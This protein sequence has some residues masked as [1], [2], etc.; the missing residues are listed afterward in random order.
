MFAWWFVKDVG[1]LGNYGSSC[2]GNSAGS[3]TIWMM[4]P[5]L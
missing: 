1:E 3:V 2:D 4:A 5:V